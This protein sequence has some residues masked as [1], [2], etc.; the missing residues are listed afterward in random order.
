MSEPKGTAKAENGILVNEG[1]P[2]HALLSLWYGDAIENKRQLGIEAE[3][4]AAI[5]AD[6]MVASAAEEQMFARFGVTK[7]TYDP[8]THTRCTAARSLILDVLGGTINRPWGLK[9][10][11]DPEVPKDVE[12]SIVAEQFGDFFKLVKAGGVKFTPDTAAAFISS[13]YDDIIESK[14][15]WAR[16]RTSRMERVADDM[17]VEG[18]FNDALTNAVDDAC[19]R[20][21]AIIG[22]TKQRV[23]CIK[24][25]TGRWMRGFKTARIYR[26]VDMAD[27]YPMPGVTEFDNGGVFVRVRWPIHVFE[28][29]MG[30]STSGW[31]PADVKDVLDQI[32]PNDSGDQP[33]DAGALTEDQVKRAEKTDASGNGRRVVSGVEC[34]VDVPE[35]ALTGRESSKS[36]KVMAVVCKSR[37]VRFRRLDRWEKP[38][39]AKAH[40]YHTPASFFGVGIPR[41]LVSAQAALNVIAAMLKRNVQMSSSASMVYNDYGSL[42]GGE[43]PGAASMDVWKVFAFRKPTSGAVSGKNIDLL[44]IES[45]VP[46]LERAYS[47]YQ[48]I[49]DEASGVPRYVYGQSSSATG[50]GRTL[51]GLRMLRDSALRGITAALAN[52]DNGI[53]KPVVQGLVD[54]LNTSEDVSDQVKCDAYVIS[55]G[56]LGMVQRSVETQERMQTLVAFSGS[57]VL[58]QVVGLKVLQSMAREVLMDQQIKGIE[59]D[60]PSREALETRELIAMLTQAAEQQQAAAGAAQAG[61]EAG[62]EGGGVPQQ[63]GDVGEMRQLQQGRAPA[64]GSVAERR[65]AA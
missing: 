8:T 45:R 55:A 65:G 48:Q 29:M 7:E 38:P 46:D 53:V 51:G 62:G 50:A 33:Q 23:P 24:N 42:I 16:T 19:I 21:T 13:R 4:L 20:G 17:L 40:F 59:E 63:P 35:S 6:R 57:P 11:P 18:G 3:M 49:A 54:D 58:G 56:V 25:S 28:K 60:M 36:V 14:V 5:N 31:R 26:R 34:W 41:V 27:V 52:L 37:I 1:A 10:S 39:Y 47:L 12:A 9:A 61:A 30:E 15:A 64:P 43:R 2:L 22:W 44:Q 32:R